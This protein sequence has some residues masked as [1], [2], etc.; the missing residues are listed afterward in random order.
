V[1]NKTFSNILA[2]RRGDWLTRKEILSKLR[3]DSGK[4]SRLIDSTFMIAVTKDEH[5]R[6]ERRRLCWRFVD[7]EK[8]YDS[9]NREALWFKMREIWIWENLVHC[10]IVDQYRW[11]QEMTENC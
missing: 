10:I 7:I 6:G 5:L 9:T 11:K 8:C 3:S 2:D 1:L 4:D